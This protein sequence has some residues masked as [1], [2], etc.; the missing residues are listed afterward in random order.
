MILNPNL[1]QLKD[2]HLPPPIHMWPIAPG[3]IIVYLLVLFVV[4][5]S[6]YAWYRRRNDQRTINY[7]L[8][9]L[10]QLQT[11]ITH[12]PHHIN[13]AAEV[14]ILIRRTALHYFKRDSIAGLAGK[15]WLT[16]LNESGCT[17]QFTSTTGQFLIDAPYRKNNKT[18][19]EPLF[20]LTKNWLMIIAKM[21]KKEK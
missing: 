12:N 14:S 19:I 7:A 21:N 3:W 10:D 9:Q 2:I 5:Y 18:D 20:A 4:G 8:R 1:Q 17:T 16:F 6:V 13:I 15:E 11:L